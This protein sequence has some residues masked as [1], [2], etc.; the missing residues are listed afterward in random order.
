MVTN[1]RNSGRWMTSHNP[2][3]RLHAKP[4]FHLLQ[5]A[6]GG[7]DRIRIQADRI[8]ASFDKEA[9]DFRIVGGR[10]S[11]DA[12]MASVAFT[13]FDSAADHFQ[14]ACVAFVEVEGDNLGI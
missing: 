5:I 14:Y 7:N 6:N 2:V 1:R 8:D 11:A 9:G 12:D 3:A 13:S 4:S 10:L